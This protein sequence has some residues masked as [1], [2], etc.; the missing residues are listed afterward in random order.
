MASS[1]QKPRTGRF[2]GSDKAW[3]AVQLSLQAIAGVGG[4]VEY[5]LAG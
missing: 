3:I 5:L 2:S 4:A 1:E